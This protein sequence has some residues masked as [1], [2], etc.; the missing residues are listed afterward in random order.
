[1]Q[2]NKLGGF[3]YKHRLNIEAESRR[4]RMIDRIKALNAVERQEE[5]PQQALSSQV[6]LVLVTDDIDLSQTS[7]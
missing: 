5:A 3:N 4:E 7:E 6:E 1:M 2:K